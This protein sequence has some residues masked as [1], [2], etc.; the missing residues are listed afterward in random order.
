MYERILLAD[1]APF[2]RKVQ[3]SIL[4]KNE[5]EICGEAAD[6]LEVIA[7]YEE[8][9]PDILI[10]GLVLPKFDGIEV[11]KQI[12][13]NYPEAKIIICSSMSRE[14]NVV[15]SMRY[16]ACNFIVKPF[17]PEVIADAVSSAKDNRIAALL[18]ERRISNWCSQQQ[19]YQPEDN[20]TQEQ[21]N[22]IVESYYRLLS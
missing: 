15:E 21:V 2:M 20:L 13:L 7:K 22:K 6:G 3:K 11:L 1:D 10:L 19:N 18:G 9:E 8:L 12:K 5:F 17:R 14:S 16:G 4:E